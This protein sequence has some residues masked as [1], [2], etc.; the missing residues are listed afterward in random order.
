[1]RKRQAGKKQLSSVPCQA[2]GR[3][4]GAWGQSRAR[5]TGSWSWL[6]RS[7]R[8]L[9]RPRVG[10]QCCHLS[11]QV[12]RHV[13]FLDLVPELSWDLRSVFVPS[14]CYHSENW[15]FLELGVMLL[16]H[17]GCFWLPVLEKS[18]NVALHTEGVDCPAPPE[19]QTWP[20]L[21]CPRHWHCWHVFLR[22]PMCPHVAVAVATQP[23]AE[24]KPPP[25]FA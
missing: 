9:A 5:E 13:G 1:M 2:A 7:S 8:A 12:C 6:L 23:V 17:V 15:E 18:L 3:W 22:V 24:Q 25:V 16:F 11:S 14:V 20:Q 4:L 10:L 19:P 21:G